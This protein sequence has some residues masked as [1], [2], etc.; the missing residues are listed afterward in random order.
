[1]SA[2]T[3]FLETLTLWEAPALLTSPS[4]LQMFPWGAPSS[5]WPP[6]TRSGCCRS[7]STG[8]P[9]DL[10]VR[11]GTAGVP[12]DREAAPLLPATSLGQTYEVRLPDTCV[13]L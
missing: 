12:E 10:K 7:P 9:Q 13:C 8:N 4:V 3:R 11:G 1:M 5:A 2:R 6:T